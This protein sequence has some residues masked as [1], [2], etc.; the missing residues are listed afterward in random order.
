MPDFIH[1][2]SGSWRSTFERHIFLLCTDTSF[3]PVPF[4]GRLRA[5]RFH[6]LTP[7]PAISS[8]SMA[9]F[10][11]KLHISQRTIHSTWSSLCRT[12]TVRFPHPRQT[13]PPPSLHT[14]AGAAHGTVHKQTLCKMDIVFLRLLGS[15]ASHLVTWIGRCRGIKCLI[16]FHNSSWLEKMILLQCA[17]YVSNLPSERWVVRALNWFPESARRVG[18]PA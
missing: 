11:L 4:M 12:P 8:Q 18:R 2:C 10:I 13:S 9:G 1:F 14:K 15:I 7:W 6:S 3:S 16:I 5:Y 17:E